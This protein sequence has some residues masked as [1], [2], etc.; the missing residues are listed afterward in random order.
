[1]RPGAGCVGAGRPARFP[2]FNKGLRDYPERIEL[3]GFAG[4]TVM[5]GGPAGLTAAV[6]LAQAGIETA[7]ISGPAPADNRTTAL[8]ASSVTALEALGGWARCRAAPAPPETLRI[9]DDTRRLWRGPGGGGFGGRQRARA[10]GDGMLKTGTLSPHC[11]PGPNKPL[12]SA[13]FAIRRLQSISPRTPSRSASR[14]AARCV[15]GC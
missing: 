15:D 11:R 5:G 3:Q 14:P 13:W 1:G 7:L 12:R 10:R 8:L 9:V 4:V 6:A 2:R